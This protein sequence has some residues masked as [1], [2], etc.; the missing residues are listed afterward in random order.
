MGTSL[1]GGEPSGNEHMD[2]GLVPVDATI[3]E[4]SCKMHLKLRE[5]GDKYAEMA[6]RRGTPST[7]Y[8]LL[9]NTDLPYSVGVMS[10]PLS[11]KFKVHQME[12]Y[13]GSKDPLE[14]LEMFKAHITL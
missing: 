2:S 12:V 7:R 13:D 3:E 9:V 4:E 6:K 5:L 8:Q 11:P 14:H 1:G 10:V